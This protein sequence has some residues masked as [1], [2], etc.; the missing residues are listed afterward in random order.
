M[1]RIFYP[2]NIYVVWHPDCRFGKTIA[3]EIYSTF[4]RDYKNPLSRGIG[5][6]VY[7]RYVKLSNE[8]PLDIDTSEAEKNAIILLIDENFFLDDDFRDYVEKLNKLVNSNNRIYPVSLCSKAH[9]I[10]C[11]LGNL[12]FIN[13]LKFNS[14]NLDLGIKEDLT[15][16]IKKIKTDILHDCSRLLMAFQPSSE[17]EDSDRMGSPVKLFLSHAKI[18]V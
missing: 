5:I 18:D 6:P 13:A 11:N 16:S 12:Q 9:T 7:F 3:E 10:G 15:L 14:R 17:D 4:C 1:N 2:L 8:Q